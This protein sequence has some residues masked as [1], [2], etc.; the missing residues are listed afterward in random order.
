[1]ENVRVIYINAKNPTLVIFERF[2]REQ[3]QDHY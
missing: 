1:M 2:Q 3:C